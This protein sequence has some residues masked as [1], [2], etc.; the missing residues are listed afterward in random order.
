MLPD[1][2]K[3]SRMPESQDP[4]LP[5]QMLLT[6][7]RALEHMLSQQRQPVQEGPNGPSPP[8]SGATPSPPARLSPPERRRRQALEQDL[9]TE[10]GWRD[11][12]DVLKPS[13][14]M[15]RFWPDLEFL[16]TALTRLEANSFTLLGGS[17][18]FPAQAR[19][20]YARLADYRAFTVALAQEGMHLARGRFGSD[21]LPAVLPAT[22]PEAEAAVLQGPT[23]AELRARAA[24][25]VR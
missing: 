4:L 13:R 5:L 10:R 3:E 15:T 20:F 21:H 9:L 12:Y 17:S 14:W 19:A 16:N 1:R 6:Q 22:T 23:L 18:A 2:E 24:T 7:L 11:G 25:E 8:S